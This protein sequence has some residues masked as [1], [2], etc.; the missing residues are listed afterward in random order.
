MVVPQFHNC[1]NHLCVVT[2]LQRAAAVAAR[3]QQRKL[4]SSTAC[5]LGA[6]AVND[7]TVSQSVFTIM[8]KALQAY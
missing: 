7:P 2:A 5:W 1:W 8:E 4:Q 6:G 3:R